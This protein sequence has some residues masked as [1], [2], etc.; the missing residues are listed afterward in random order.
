LGICQIVIVSCKPPP[1][2][3]INSGIILIFR[4]KVRKIIGALDFGPSVVQ[5]LIASRC[6][7]TAVAKWLAHIRLYRVRAKWHKTEHE[8]VTVAGPFSK[9]D[10]G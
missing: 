8:I 2:G 10:D 6:S 7:G 1:V 4:R 3:K 5:N 9:P